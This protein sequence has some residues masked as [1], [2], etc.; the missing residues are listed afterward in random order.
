MKMCE[1]NFDKFNKVALYTLVKLFDAFPEP[2]FV[3]P[4]K[5]T[6]EALGSDKGG[7]EVQIFDNEMKFGYETL[8]WLESEGFITVKQKP[9]N[10]SFHGVRLTLKGLTLLGY[11]MPNQGGET[12]IDQ[13]KDVL[14]G[15]VKDTAKDVLTKLFTTAASLTIAA[16][17]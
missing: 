17:G 11:S 9:L 13:A 1:T 10:G 7:D 6:V 15:A 4:T 2:I 5:Y 3:D 16:M 8:S 14:S 12:F